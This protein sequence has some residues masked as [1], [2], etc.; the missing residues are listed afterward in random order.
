MLFLTEMQAIKH[1]IIP[2][3]LFLVKRVL[4]VKAMLFISTKHYKTVY[5]HIKIIKVYNCYD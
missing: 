1:F 3:F 4:H 2:S 5:L